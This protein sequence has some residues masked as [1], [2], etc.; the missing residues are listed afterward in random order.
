MVN[1]HISCQKD[2]Q[3]AT[4]FSSFS[5]LLCCSAMARAMAP[6]EVSLLPFRLQWNTSDMNT[7]ELDL[8]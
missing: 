6:V 2:T 7:P 5:D 4:H 3:D 1:G 8:Q